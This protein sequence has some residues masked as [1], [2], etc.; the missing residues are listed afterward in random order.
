MSSAFF[1]LN[2]AYT[3]LIAANA[4]LNTTANNIANIE[5]DGYSRQTVR[6]QAAV[7]LRTYASYGC[8]GAGV[9]TLSAER[10]RNEYYDVKYR[11]NNANLG[12]YDKKA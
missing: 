8:A 4:G 5:T 11:N 6:Q 2:T 10:Q 1:G 9:D 12:Q 3:G 7:A